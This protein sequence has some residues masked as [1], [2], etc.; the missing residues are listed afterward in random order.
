MKLKT[1]FSLVI[2]LLLASWNARAATIFLTIPGNTPWTDTGILVG[3]GNGVTII[4]SN[5]VSWGGA[6]TD[7]NGVGPF[8][9]GT[10][11]LPTV[12]VPT[13]IIDSLVGKVGGTTAIGTG[14]ALPEG[15]PGKGAGFVGSPYSQISPVSGELFLGFNDDHFEDNSGSYS[16]WITV[17]PE[18]SSVALI[19]L[20]IA[21]VS[22]KARR[23][24][25]AGKSA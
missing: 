21:V 2:G 25:R 16:V 3:A 10:Q 19:G 9:D 7:P 14:T 17:V 24:K 1:T 5:T 4:A 15:K 22:V 13:A 23:L 18:P 6:S 20:G 8:R 12:I 11:M